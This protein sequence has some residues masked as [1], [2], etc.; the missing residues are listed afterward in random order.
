MKTN[1]Q[2]KA[3]VYYVIIFYTLFLYKLYHG[4]LLCQ[5]QP[6]FLFLRDDIF[7]WLFMQAYLPQWLLQHP[8]YFIVFDVAFYTAPL[9]FLYAVVKKQS[10]VP[11]AAFAMLVINWIYIQCYTLYPTSSITLYIAWLLFPVAFLAT[12]RSLFYSL[13]QAL[14]Y[15]FLY[16]FFFC[17]GM[18]NC[19]WRHFQPVANERHTAGPA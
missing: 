4:L 11:V 12:N 6:L 15:F 19:K 1:L 10:I 9:L 17:R 14:R 3:A 7:S 18:E 5:L 8:Q 16:F 2:Y 13:L